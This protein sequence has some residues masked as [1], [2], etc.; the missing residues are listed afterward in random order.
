MQI[1]DL[2]LRVLLLFFPGVICCKLVDNLTVHKERS[3]AMFIVHSFILGISCYLLLYVLAWVL[4]KGNALIDRTLVF[5][6]VFFDALT[7]SNTKLRWP[8]ILMAA[9]LSFPFALVISFLHG[10]RGFG[11]W[12]WMTSRIF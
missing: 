3:T 10:Y 11:S 5:D 7:D 4:V 6:I 9:G 1:S 12:P 2:T 8:E